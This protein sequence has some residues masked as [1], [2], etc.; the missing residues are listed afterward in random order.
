[1]GQQDRR[2]L[3]TSTPRNATTRS[4]GPTPSDRLC[5][6]QPTAVTR[7][8]DLK[9]ALTGFNV[10]DYRVTEAFLAWVEAH[11][12]TASEALT[13]VADRAR[14]RSRST[15]SSTWCHGT[16][17]PGWGRGSASPP[18]CCWAV[19]PEQLPPWR[20]TAARAT[21]RL[22]GGYA[23]EAAATAGEIYLGW[24][25]RLD[26]ITA[27]VN[28]DPDDRCC[29]TGLTPKDSRTRC[30]EPIFVLTVG[31]PPTVRRWPAGS[32][33]GAPHR[34][35]SGARPGPALT[36]VRS[37][38]VS[39]S[40]ELVDDLYLDELGAAWLK[41]TLT[42]LDRKRQL[43]FQGPPG[44]GKTFMARKVARYL[45]GADDRVTTVQF[46]PG[47]SYEDFVQG[48]RPDPQRP[49]PVHRRRRAVDH[50][51][52]RRREEP[53]QDLCAADR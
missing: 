14:D 27:A 36:Q 21:Q 47:T 52:R 16:T 22:S 5:R 44:T 10:V 53:D 35:A 12:D 20:D 32:K 49:E 42:L 4:N 45:A 50:D 38:P 1:M 15:G 43:I 41:E 26:M 39:R 48:L 19:L 8:S 51:R 11:P 7:I 25:E 2:P 37:R 13:D 9:T 3:S 31:P 18:R 23:N 30:S 17:C 33:G 40:I 24:L 34:P 46:H 29:E 6:S 28:V